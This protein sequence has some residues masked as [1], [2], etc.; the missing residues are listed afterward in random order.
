VEHGEPK[1]VRNNPDWE[2][3]ILCNRNFFWNGPTADGNGR[4][5]RLLMNYQLMASG[6]PAISIPKE[7]RLEYFNTLEA[8]AVE[9]NLAPFS[10]MVAELTQQ[11]LDRCLGMIG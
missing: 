6:F 7:N 11:Q 2:Y 10:D 4:T 8:Y 1:T 9:R 3:N 5:S